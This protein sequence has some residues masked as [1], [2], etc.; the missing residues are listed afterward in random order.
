MILDV[1]ECTL[2]LVGVLDTLVKV[3]YLVG[4]VGVVL[5]AVG[6]SA[7]VRASRRVDVLLDEPSLLPASD[8]HLLDVADCAEVVPRAEA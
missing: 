7:I 6:V 2:W 8:E 1:I 4:A 5:A 3:S